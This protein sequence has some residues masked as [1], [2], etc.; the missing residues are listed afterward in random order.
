MTIDLAHTVNYPL[1]VLSLVVWF[2]AFS[3]LSTTNCFLYDLKTHTAVLASILYIY[4][5]CLCVC[6][7]VGWE[8]EV[9]HSGIPWAVGF[10][11]LTRAVQECGSSLKHHFETKSWQ[12][13]LVPHLSG[14]VMAPRFTI[15][16]VIRTSCSTWTPVVPAF[17]DWPSHL[18]TDGYLHECLL[19]IHPFGPLFPLMNCHSS[20]SFYLSPIT[21]Q[22]N[23]GERKRNYDML[24]PPMCSQELYLKELFTCF[25]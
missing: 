7:W 2:N 24:F 9:T 10:N 6:V 8:Q 25:L 15:S 18:N 17:P 19:R 22:T 21:G 4:N 16:F 3:F 14:T 1:L 11:L 13:V 5:V 23:A 20:T 12:T